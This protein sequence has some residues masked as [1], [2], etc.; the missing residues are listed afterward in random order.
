MSLSEASVEEIRR[1]LHDLRIGK[2]AS[3]ASV[4]AELARHEIDT[5]P[6]EFLKYIDA[7]TELLPD[8][9]QRAAIRGALALGGNE[10]ATLSRRRTRVAYEIGVDVRTVMR[11]EEPATE[12]A[13]KI[14]HKLADP[15]SHVKLVNVA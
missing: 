7:A 11:R 4:R 5:D 3:L 6:M 14:M 8:D 13:A 12:S 1:V 9:E 2:G 10:L 15:K